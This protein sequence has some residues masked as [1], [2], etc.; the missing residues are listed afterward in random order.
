MRV[1]ILD[2]F[3]R[4]ARDGGRQRVGKQLRT[5]TLDERVDERVASGDEAARR[6]AERFAERSRD[7]V[8]LAGQPV[9]LDGAASGFAHDAGSVRIV[10]DDDRAVALARAPTISGSF[11]RSPSIEN[12]PS[13]TTTIGKQPATAF[14]L[15]LEI[16]HVAVLVSLAARLASRAARRR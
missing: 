7:D 15:L 1:E 9:M 14:E 13:V 16:A 2:R 12:T 3:E 5:R 8:D 6:A 10:D 11:A 4:A